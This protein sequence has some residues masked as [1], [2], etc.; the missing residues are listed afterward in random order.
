MLF[1]FTQY[2]SSFLLLGRLVCFKSGVSDRPAFGVYELE[3]VRV[4][5]QIR[6]LVQITGFKYGQEHYGQRKRALIRIC[7][8]ES[9]RVIQAVFAAW[10]GTSS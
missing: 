6:N 4:V 3:A 2:F 5:I 8:T 1:Q 7:G 9:D 10:I